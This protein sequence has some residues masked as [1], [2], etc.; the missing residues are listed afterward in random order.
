[1]VVVV[2]FE[3]AR[4]SW[5]IWEWKK[6]M[7][8]LEMGWKY[9][10]LKNLYGWAL[11]DMIDIEIKTYID[12]QIIHY[13][14]SQKNSRWK[15]TYRYILSIIV[16]Y[17]VN[18]FQLL[19]KYRRTLSVYE[20]VGDCGIFSKYFSTLDKMPTDFICLWKRRWLCHF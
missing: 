9:I 18:I 17:P 11:M 10:E 6:Y 14:I 1:M 4:W 2:V 15:Y 7:Y 12:K 3:K 16:A 13:K 20:G 5:N 19:V 8:K